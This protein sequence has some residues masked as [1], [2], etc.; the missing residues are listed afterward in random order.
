MFVRTLSR[1]QWLITF[2]GI[3]FAWV[4]A[5]GRYREDIMTEVGGGV[6]MLIENYVGQRGFDLGDRVD[7]L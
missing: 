2:F 4:D 1:V 3:E 5:V 6:T 7:Q